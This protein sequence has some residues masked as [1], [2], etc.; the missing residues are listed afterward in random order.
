MSRTKAELDENDEVSEDFVE[1]DDIEEP[2]PETLNTSR[3]AED[4]EAALEEALS[5]NTQY[6]RKM[7][8]TQMY[9]GEIGFSP[10]LTAEDEV[11]YSRR[12]RR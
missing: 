12:E 8:A 10:L 1:D 4:E 3:I 9:L 5:S 6:Q 7:D 2:Q 11:F